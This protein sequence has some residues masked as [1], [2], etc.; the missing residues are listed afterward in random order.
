M[1]MDGRIIEIAIKWMKD[2]H[3]LN[4]VD[5][6]TEPGMDGWMAAMKLENLGGLHEKLKISIENHGSRIVAL[7]GHSD[8]A[9][10][11]TDYQ[12]HLTHLRMGCKK[13]KVLVHEIAPDLKVDV[14]TLFVDVDKQTVIE[15]TDQED[16]AA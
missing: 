11:P 5:T 4:W 16:L 6:V 2:N 12:T 15:I 3:E 9:G 13:I 7:F 10:N 1:C 8:C 14:V